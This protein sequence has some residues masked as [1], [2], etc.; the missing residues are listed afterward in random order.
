MGQLLGEGSYRSLLHTLDDL[1]DFHGERRQWSVRFTVGPDRIDLANAF[2]IVQG[3]GGRFVALRLFDVPC[4]AADVGNFRSVRIVPFEVLACKR[5][6]AT[7]R[8]AHAQ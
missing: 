1:A 4:E 6:K 3:L 7:P 8:P 2:P 5:A